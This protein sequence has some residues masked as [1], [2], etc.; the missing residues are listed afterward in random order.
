MKCNIQVDW[1]AMEPLIKTVLKDDMAQLKK[2]L[3]YIK[4]SKRGYV[5][6]LDWKEDVG[7]INK[8]LDAYKLIV[9]YYGG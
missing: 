3:A 8:H 2:D 4:K 9:R 1:E 6:S 5:F 7:A